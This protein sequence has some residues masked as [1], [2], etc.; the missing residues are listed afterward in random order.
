MSDAR[1]VTSLK[2]G[3]PHEAVIHP[4]N[5]AQRRPDIRVVRACLEEGNG[6]ALEDG[7]CPRLAPG[8]SRSAVFFPMLHEE[9]MCVSKH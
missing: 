3:V 2:C 8:D 5:R 4:P 1:L 6:A 7:V 9:A